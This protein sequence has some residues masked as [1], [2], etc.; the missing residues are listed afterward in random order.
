M[1][2]EIADRVVTLFYGAWQMLVGVIALALRVVE[3]GLVKVLIVTRWLADDGDRQLRRMA[4][5]AKMTPT[6]KVTS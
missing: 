3:Y 1:E 5:T 2:Q 6:V 4:V